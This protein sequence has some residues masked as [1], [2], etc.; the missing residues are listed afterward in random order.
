MGLK[1]FYG[2]VRTSVIVGLITLTAASVGAAGAQAKVL[3]DFAEHSTLPQWT[4]VNDTVMGG[5]SKGGFELTDGDT[6]LFSGRLSLENN[7][8][9]TSI[10]SKPADL[11][12]DGFDTLTVRL[13]GDGRTYSMDLR[14]RSTR[15]ASS[16]RAEVVTKDGEWA[17]YA[18]PLKSFA[19]TSFGRQLGGYG[20]VKAADITTVGFTLADKVPGPFALEIDWIK[21][22]N[23]A[24]T[25]A[26]DKPASSLD[27]V[28]TATAAG[29]FKTL[30]A[31]AQAAGLVDALRAKGPITVFAPTDDA[32]AKLPDGTVQG[33][34]KPENRDNLISILTYHVVQGNVRLGT[35]AAKTVEGQN[36]TIVPGAFSVNGAK[37]L[38]ANVEASNGLIHVIDTVLLPPKTAK[39]P[40]ESAQSVIELAIDRGV[41][42]F[43][44]GNVAACAAVYE[45]ALDSL[46]QGH[47]KALTNTDREAIRM[48]LEKARAKGKDYRTNAW[49]F[50]HALDSVSASLSSN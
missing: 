34:L 36:L 35:Q 24:V 25:G 38:A 5:R 1:E 8:G 47:T 44:D 17:T 46:L 39:T 11:G 30:I 40:Q 37:V 27:L 23:R 41:P 18:I 42:L 29:Q 31:A 3:F 19:Y 13:K 22:G 20:M 14:T 43:N 15:M 49:T 9:F 21:A 7:G 6:L 2:L 12:L 26:G 50:R 4:A 45:V 10:R 32:F 16:Y 48:A 28:A 33:L